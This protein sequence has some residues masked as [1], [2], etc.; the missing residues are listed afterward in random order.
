[1]TA[2]I[3]ERITAKEAE[4]EQ[5]R[6]ASL[7]N[8]ERQVG[9]DLRGKQWARRV[10]SQ[11]RR[12]AELGRQAERL[13]RDLAGLRREAKQGPPPPLDLSKLPAAKFI[14][15]TYGW[16]EVVKVNRATVKVLAAPG[17]DDLIKVSKILAI[18]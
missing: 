8:F 6:A 18:R 14:R 17:M 1:M 11:L 7:A 4:L 2:P 3:A 12:G 10:D 5:T 16:Y 15:T 9:G 13:E